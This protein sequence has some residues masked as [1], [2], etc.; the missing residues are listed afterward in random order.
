MLTFLFPFSGIRF[1]ERRGHHL[2]GLGGPLALGA[3]GER[4]AGGDLGHHSRTSLR[5][6]HGK[7]SVDHCRF[8]GG[9]GGERRKK[10]EKEKDDSL[11]DVFAGACLAWC[12]PL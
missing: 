10:K 2:R 11:C 7:V 5:A 3:D 12:L 6:L 8:A 4:D 9:G 1:S